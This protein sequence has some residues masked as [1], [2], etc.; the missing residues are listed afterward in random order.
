MTQ[1]VYLD[2]IG[3]RLNQS[4][5]ATMSRQFESL[6][7]Q[8]VSDPAQ[9]DLMVVNTCAVTADATKDSRKLIRNLQRQAQ[10]AQIAVTGCYAH[11]DPQTVAGLP[12]VT[13]VLDNFQ[14]EGLVAHVTGQIPEPYD[15][16]PIQRHYQPHGAD[17]TRAYVKVQDG[18]DNQCTF[19]VTRI[20]R[21]AGRSRPSEAIVREVQWLTESGYQEVVLTGVHL[22]SYGHDLGQRWGLY[23]LL[24][25]LLSATAIP[26]IRLSSL[27]PWDLAPHFFGLWQ[28]SR[29]C[30]HLHLPLQ[31]GC[32]ATLKRM[33]RNTS[34]AEFACLVDSARAQIPGL[35]LSTDLIVGFP[36]EDENEFDQSYNFTAA[37]DFMKIHVF[38]FSPREGTPAARM[39]GR[40]D[41]PTA[42]AR[43]HRIQALSDVG[44]ARFQQ[45]HI[46]QTLVVVWEHI[47]G[48]SEEGFWHSGLTDNYIRVE[49]KHPV[50]HSNCIT[51]ALLTQCL[52]NGAM[53]G[54]IA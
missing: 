43:L 38:P 19:C 23:E 20:A 9:A 46:G 13:L 48:A 16:E 5:I 32:D 39:K 34:Q 12:N 53:H 45:A 21:G 4:E 15:L 33:R 1:R 36:G 22:G 31:S 28:D 42:K 6:G 51:P 18:C 50:I 11:I 25:A 27:E 26:R 35:A 49:T 40:I 44:L 30:R 14:K 3:C 17:L 8:V 47:R 37:M 41:K 2:S 29:L 52:P 7:Y 10:D 54:V 24:Q